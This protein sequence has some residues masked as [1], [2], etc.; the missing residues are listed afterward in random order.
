MDWWREEFR[1]QA[2]SRAPL[3]ERNEQQLRTHVRSYAALPSS[4]KNRIIP[5]MDTH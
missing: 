5:G 4:E 1:Q 2:D 3:S